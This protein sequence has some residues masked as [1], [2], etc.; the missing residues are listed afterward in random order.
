MKLFNVVK[1]GT[2]ALAVSFM[3]LAVQA[4]FD[5]APPSNGLHNLSLLKPPAGSKVAIVVFED[6]GCPACAHA[7]PIELQVAAATHVPILR[8]DFPFAQHIWTQQGAVCARYI[9]NKIS[10]S[11]ADQYRSD[12]FAAQNSIANKDDLQRFTENW[13]QRHNQRMPFVMDPDGSLANAVRSDYE[14]GRRINVGFTPTIVV[15]SKDKQQVVCGT[16]NNNYDDPTRIRSV[17]DAAVAQT[18]NA[19]TPPQPAKPAKSGRS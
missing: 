3:P 4:Q 7:H 9:Q 19:A 10:P 11:L 16:G 1:L 5:G 6:L 2:L 18:R 15:I 12:V 14:L 13:L 8:F 17:V